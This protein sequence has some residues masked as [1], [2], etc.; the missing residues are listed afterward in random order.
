M[1]AGRAAAVQ[2]E[3]D[4]D[5][6]EECDP[7]N[8]QSG[9]WQETWSGY[10]GRDISRLLDEKLVWRGTHYG[11]SLA[12]GWARLGLFASFTK[13]ELITACGPR[14]VC[15]DDGDL[16]EKP[17][18]EEM[19]CEQCSAE[20]EVTTPPGELTNY[21]VEC[22][23]CNRIAKTIVRLDPPPVQPLA[24][25]NIR[26]PKK[27]PP[28]ERKKPLARRGDR[29]A[30]D[31]SDTDVDL[32]PPS[33]TG[34]GHLRR[35]DRSA[36]TVSDT[37]DTDTALPARARTEPG[38]KLASHATMCERPEMPVE[39][40]LLRV[41]YPRDDE[42]TL[43]KPAWLV[44][45]G[46]RQGRPPY[47]NV[48]LLDLETLQPRAEVVTIQLDDVSER[49]FSESE[50]RRMRLDTRRWGERREDWIG[51]S[52]IRRMRLDT[53]RW[54]ERREDWDGTR[55]HPLELLS[56]LKLLWVEHKLRLREPEVLKAQS[57]RDEMLYA[58]A[59]Y[60]VSGVLRCVLPRAT[61]TLTLAG[62]RR[63]SLMRCHPALWQYVEA[64]ARL[65][66]TSSAAEQL[67]NDRD[68]RRARL[69]PRR[70]ALRGAGVGS[71]RTR[72]VPAGRCE[73]RSCRELAPPRASRGAA[74]VGRRD[75]V[76][77]LCG[78][79][80]QARER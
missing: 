75:C 20:I 14:L 51:T 57:L 24:D 7:S 2:L 8:L 49:W 60:G 62:R 73:C 44:D 58:R 52:E 77:A 70:A 6:L 39:D 28:R 5:S 22:F 23:R 65:L 59:G 13:S 64:R 69:A 76:G 10:Q 40:V 74:A 53:R 67:A 3:C 56:R 46:F 43:Y 16:L 25:D 32:P 63:R 80:R 37:G 11:H 27:P 54:G 9:P 61:T 41:M 26:C 68:R 45:V 4:P 35:G 31:T 34:R 18:V 47:I 21:E 78:L 71:H 38:N 79:G 42:V 66:G 72:E 48:R 12:T 36:A 30:S 33:R 50:I 15:G 19:T 29:S 55:E 1:S 17:V